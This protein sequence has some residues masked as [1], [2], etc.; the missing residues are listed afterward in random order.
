MLEEEKAE[1]RCQPY[2]RNLSPRKIAHCS[3]N[4]SEHTVGWFGA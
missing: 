3:D 2:R 1:G 4:F